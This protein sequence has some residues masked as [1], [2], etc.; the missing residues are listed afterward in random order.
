MRIGPNRGRTSGSRSITVTF[1]E[2]PAILTGPW[3]GNRRLG[4]RAVAIAAKTAS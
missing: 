2:L 1:P 4:F 3:A